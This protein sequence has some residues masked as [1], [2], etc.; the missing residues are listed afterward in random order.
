MTLEDAL[1]CANNFINMEDD[2]DSFIIK[3]NAT[4]MQVGKSADAYQEPRQHTSYD[5]KDKKIIVYSITENRKID[6]QL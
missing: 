6:S 3:H 5:E 4:K 1:H 2:K